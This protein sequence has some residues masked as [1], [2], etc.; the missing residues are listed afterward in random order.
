MEY[1]KVEVQSDDDYERVDEGRERG[2]GGEGSIKKER[3]GR[4]KGEEDEEEG[5]VEVGQRERGERERGERGRGKIREKDEGEG[6]FNPF[7]RKRWKKR[8]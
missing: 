4:Y 6:T 3:R 8:N 7:H 1:S 5:E 2:S